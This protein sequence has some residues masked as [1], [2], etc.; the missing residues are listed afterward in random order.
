MTIGRTDDPENPPDSPAFE[1]A[2]LFGTGSRTPSGPADIVPR[3]Q[4]G[5]MIA[6]D[7]PVKIS[8]KLLHPRGRPHM[9]AGWTHCRTTNRTVRSPTPCGRLSTSISQNSRRSSR[10]GASEVIEQRDDPFGMGHDDA[11]AGG[12]AFAGCRR[13]RALMPG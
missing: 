4:A 6:I 11:H 7:P 2:T 12:P 3:Q 13:K 5:H 1:A 8:S 9:S 10:H